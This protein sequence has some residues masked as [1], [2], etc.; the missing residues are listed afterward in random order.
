MNSPS[1]PR[2]IEVRV[3]APVEWCELVAETLAIGP[4][5][6]VAFGRPSLGT[7]A[8]PEG[9]D[10][11]RTFV[12]TRDDTPALRA[13]I[14]EALRE[15]AR[16]TGAP[17]LADTSVEFR[18]LPPEDYATSWKKSWK[19]FRVGRLCVVAP[20]TTFDGAD[21]AREVLPSDAGGARSA[22]LAARASRSS[23]PDARV[24]S[25]R[26]TCGVAPG[27]PR[28]RD[29]VLSIEPGGAFGSGRH[30]T[31]RTCMRVLLERLRGG[32]RVLDA[33]SGSGI[34]SVTAALC[35][36]RDVFGFDT[37]PNAEPYATELAVGNGVGDRCR[38][39]SG[40]FETLAARTGPHDVV[41]A[42]IYSDVIQAFAPRLRDA[43]APRG[44][45]AFSGCP[46]HHAEPTRAAIR[47]A[48]LSID[49]E[50]ARGRWHTF[51]GRRA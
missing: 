29:L 2:W 38:F 7:D 36:A 39:V 43:L 22:S 48:G 40:G 26:A 8:P 6:S 31:T 28:A 30:A 15:L 4:C 51:V 47:A 44:W 27:R 41:L 20:W 17:E 32:E 16:A 50:R 42:N 25:P 12:V 11:V 18:P 19:P 13:S 34:L 45:F 5:T 21:P 23:T 33:G 3:L 10:Y 24:T 35:G 46:A 1:T 37:D 49:E 9:F 14:E